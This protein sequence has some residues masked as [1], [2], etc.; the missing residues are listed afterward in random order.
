ME[1]DSVAQNIYANMLNDMLS[2]LLPWKT[3]IMKTIKMA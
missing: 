2:I 1:E 3:V